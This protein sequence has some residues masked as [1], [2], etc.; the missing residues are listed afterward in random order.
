MKQN[1]TKSGLKIIKF[2]THPCPSSLLN[3]D[4][5]VFKNNKKQWFNE[6]KGGLNYQV[7]FSSEAE[8]SESLSVKTV[9]RSVVHPIVLTATI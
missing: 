3:L 9:K 6:S 1:S 8:L 2:C 7:L 4:V 5:W